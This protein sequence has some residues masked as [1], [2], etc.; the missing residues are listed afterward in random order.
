MYFKTNKQDPVAT[1][2]SNIQQS[3]YVS[4]YRTF[5]TGSYFSTYNLLDKLS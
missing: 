2:S 1:S 4:K 5:P 3:N